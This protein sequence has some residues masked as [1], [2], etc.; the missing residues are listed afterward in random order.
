MR[1]ALWALLTAARPQNAQAGSAEFE[2]RH[3]TGA[4]PVARQQCRNASSE[5]DEYRGLR[6]MATRRRGRAPAP[7]RHCL[8]HHPRGRVDAV[9]CEGAVAGASGQRRRDLEYYAREPGDTSTS[10]ANTWEG[11]GGCYMSH[12]QNFGLRENS[13]SRLAVFEVSGGFS[14]PAPTRKHPG[15]R[16]STGHDAP[17]FLR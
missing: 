16:A 15:S 6:H 10:F 4:P 2:E 7:A 17:G 11:S 1:S 12:A 3:P 13:H 8:R 14:D 9:V 5:H